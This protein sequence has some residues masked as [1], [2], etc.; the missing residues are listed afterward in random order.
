MVFG[1]TWCLVQHGVAPDVEEI[2]HHG[3]IYFATLQIYFLLEHVGI[4]LNRD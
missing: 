1:A 4:I 3:F 2:E